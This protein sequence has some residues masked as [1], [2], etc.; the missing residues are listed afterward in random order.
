MSPALPCST[1]QVRVR[2]AETD[3]MGI[4]YHANYL[5]WMEVGR[6]EACR[7]LG[8]EYKDME[9][10]DGIFLAV[11]EVNARY[12]YPA[13]YDDLVTIATTLGDVSSRRVIFKYEMHCGDRKLATG[14]TS[15]IFLNRELKP[16]RIPQKY[17]PLFGIA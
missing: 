11:T 3:Q 8:F 12:L 9:Q 7:E 6:I 10:K 13:R 16:T 14:Q 5:V 2:Y 4:V 17:H 15:H 1:T